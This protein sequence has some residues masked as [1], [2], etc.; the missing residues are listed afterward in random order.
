[1]AD[2]T[3]VFEEGTTRA[4]YQPVSDWKTFLLLGSCSIPTI[5][6]VMRVLF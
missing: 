1:M 3:N 2:L 5:F 6:V 4:D